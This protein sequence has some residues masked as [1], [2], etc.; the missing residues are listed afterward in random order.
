MRHKR[1]FK[2][3]DDFTLK[4]QKQKHQSPGT[5]YIVQSIKS[6]VLFYI[7]TYLCSVVRAIKKTQT[8]FQAVLLWFTSFHG[9]VKGTLKFS[10]KMGKVLLCFA[11]WDKYQEKLLI[12]ACN[13]IY[14][15]NSLYSGFKGHFDFLI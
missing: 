8:S 3:P 15:L 11:G 6:S 13:L 10:R 14:A 1:F 5:V 9:Y 7:L 2:N 4:E 12:K